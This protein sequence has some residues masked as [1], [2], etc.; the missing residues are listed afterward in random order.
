[1]AKKGTDSPAFILLPMIPSLRSAAPLNSKA[2]HGARTPSSASLS[3]TNS[4]ETPGKKMGGKKWIILLQRIP[5]FY[6]PL[7]EIP[8][9]DRQ[10]NG[11]RR[12]GSGGVHDGC[13]S[14]PFGLPSSVCPMGCVKCLGPSPLRSGCLA[15]LGSS[16]I[17]H[18]SSF[19]IH[20]SPPPLGNS[21]RCG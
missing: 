15:S 21:C 3:M 16:F 5:P 2:G 18:H 4:A 12:M 20:P 14:L 13:A 17:I 7:R 19:I 1:M 8:R 10:K 11:G 6:Q 9:Q